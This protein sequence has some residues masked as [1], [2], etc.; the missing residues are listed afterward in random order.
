MLLFIRQLISVVYRHG[1]H[2]FQII[3]LIYLIR[4]TNN[5]HQIFV[6]VRCVYV[7]ESLYCVIVC[8]FG[9]TVA[10]SAGRAMAMTNLFVNEMIRH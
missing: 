10:T 5:G 6:Y 4:T 8:F 1:L 3:I 9:D 2:A 7:C